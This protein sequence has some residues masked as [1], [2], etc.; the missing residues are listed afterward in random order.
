MLHQAGGVAGYI[1]AVVLVVAGSG[2][3]LY[4]SLPNSLPQDLVVNALP[5]ELNILGRVMYGYDMPL[6]DRVLRILEYP[7]YI[8]RRYVA[9]DA[10]PIYLSFIYH[11]DNRK[12]VH[13]PDVCVEGGGNDIVAKTNMDVRG[14]LGQEVVPSRELLVINSQANKTYHLYVYRCGDTYTRSFWYQQWVIFIN[15]LQNRNSSSGLIHI[16]TPVT[17][18][19]KTAQ[20]RCVEMIRTILPYLD[21]E[22]HREAPGNN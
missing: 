14:V 6:S 15:G 19:V 7:S 13:P 16:T 5:R 10:D 21:K 3:V 8:N 17:T 11:K 22:L 18:D 9:P 20:Q 4:V 12:A 2:R 1:V